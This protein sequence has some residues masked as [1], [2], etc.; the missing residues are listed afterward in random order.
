GK[1]GKNPKSA[2]AHFSVRKSKQ[3]ATTSHR[4][5]PVLTCSYIRRNDPCVAP[6]DP[7][8]DASFHREAGLVCRLLSQGYQQ[9]LRCRTGPQRRGFRR[10]RGKG[11]WARRR[12]WRRQVDIVENHSRCVAARF[13]R[14][15]V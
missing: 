14:A 10:R 12:Q 2:C 11:K 9:T 3:V 7:R 15:E 13:R 8:S 6:L 1:L 4:P 5:C